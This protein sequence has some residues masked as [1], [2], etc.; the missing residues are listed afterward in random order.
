MKKKFENLAKYFC[1]KKQIPEDLKQ[2]FENLG[3]YFKKTNNHKRN[4]KK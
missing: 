4:K 2:K 1:G 3:E